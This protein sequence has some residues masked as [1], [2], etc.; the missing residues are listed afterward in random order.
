MGLYVVWQT[1]TAVPNKNLNK[2][3]VCVT[4]IDLQILCVDNIVSW[5]RK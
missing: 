5:N 3:S 1:L 4:I 2:Y